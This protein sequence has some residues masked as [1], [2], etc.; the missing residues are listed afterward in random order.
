M[1]ALLD[2][3]FWWAVAVMD[4]AARVLTLAALWRWIRT[5]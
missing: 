5:K 1:I 3:L 4:W 2:W